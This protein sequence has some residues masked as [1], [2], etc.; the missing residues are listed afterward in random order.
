M[1]PGSSFA[2]YGILLALDALVNL[3]TMYGDI[4]RGIHSESDLISLDP[5]NGYGHFV[6]DHKGLAYAARKDQ[7]DFILL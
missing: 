3:F 6:P 4:F 1:A 5:E 7:H 2:F